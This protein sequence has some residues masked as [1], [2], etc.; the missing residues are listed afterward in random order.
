MCEM[1]SDATVVYI[2]EDI[3]KQWL[4]KILQKNNF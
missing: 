3:R 2:A 4:E 1:L